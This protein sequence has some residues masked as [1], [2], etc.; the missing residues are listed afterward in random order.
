MPSRPPRLRKQRNSR[1]TATR[2]DAA[3]LLVF[4]AMESEDPEQIAD[5]MSRALE[6]DP[7]CTDARLL[8]L[9]LYGGPLASQF[10]MLKEI[11]D[12]AAQRLGSDFFREHTGHFW[13]I[14]ETRSYMRARFQLA[15]SYAALGE[16]SDAVRELE[17]LLTLCPGDNLGARYP[18]VGHYFALWRFEE[19]SSRLE[20]MADDALASAAWARVLER[21]LLGTEQEAREVLHLARSANPHV[22][23][24]LAGGIPLPSQPPDSWMWGSV[25]EAMMTAFHL[26][27]A[28]RRN[29]EVMVWLRGQK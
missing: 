17:G 7:A 26:G 29:P 9:E 12:Q 1:P 15:L 28:Y 8:A 23:R 13:L 22:E 6:L 18:L 3:Q 10:E 25:E 21:F 14:P 19:A 24:Y 27:E 11:T 20:S 5:L 16:E 2:I 4:D